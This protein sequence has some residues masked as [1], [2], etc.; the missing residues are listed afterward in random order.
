MM[1]KLVIIYFRIDGGRVL[2]FQGK[3][4][5]RA[6]LGQKACIV[7]SYIVNSLTEVVSICN[8]TSNIQDCLFLHSL[9]NTACAMLFNFHQ[10]DRW[11]R[12]LSVVLVC[13]SLIISRSFKWE[14]VR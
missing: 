1:D 9:A 5:G 3:F 6:L 14:P 7:L 13:I 2:Y 10:F 12:Y 8:P 11:K 4:L